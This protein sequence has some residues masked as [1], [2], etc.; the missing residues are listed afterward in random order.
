MHLLYSGMNC[1]IPCSYQSMF[2]V[3]IRN[4]TT[5][6]TSQPSFSFWLQRFCV[7]SNTGNSHLAN[8]ISDIITVSVGGAV[9]KLSDISIFFGLTFVVEIS[10]PYFPTFS[11]QFLSCVWCK[12]NTFLIKLPQ[13]PKLSE[14]LH[15]TLQNYRFL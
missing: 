13:L 8:D 2:C 3:I 9:M 11:I 6:F 1:S 5:V 10:V 15:R 4:V 14:F 12:L 7:S